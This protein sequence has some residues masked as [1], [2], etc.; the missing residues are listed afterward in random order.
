[1][2]RADCIKSIIIGVAVIAAALIPYFL[3]ECSFRKLSPR[4]ICIYGILA[5]IAFAFYKKQKEYPATIC[6]IVVGIVSVVFSQ[7]VVLGLTYELTNSFESCFNSVSFF[8]IWII[9][10]PVYSI[11]FYYGLLGGVLLLNKTTITHPSVHVDKKKLLLIILLS[12]IVYF[13][14]FYP[15]VF[16]FDAAV[17]LRTLLDP[18]CATCNHHPYFIQLIHGCFFGLG[19]LLG[20][21]SVG[22]ALLSL[23]LIATSVGILYYTVILLEKANIN[24]KWIISIILIYSLLPI[25]PYLSVYPTKDGIFAYSFLLYLLTLY[26]LFITRGQCLNQARFLC[27][28]FIAGLLICLSRHQGSI[29]FVIEAIV[30]LIAYKKYWQRLLSCSISVLLLHLGFTKII[31]PLND[32]EPA[33]KQETYGILFQQTAYCLKQYPDDVTA[34]EREAINTILNCDTIV[35]KYEASKTDAVKNTYKYNPW[36]RVAPNSPSMFRH[37]DRTN[38]AEELAAY[39]SAWLS[40]FLRHPLTHIEASAAVFWGFFYNNGQPLILAEPTWAENPSATT[41]EY[42]FWHINKVAEWIKKKNETI[43]QTPIINWI[44]AIPYY[45]WLAIFLLSILFLRNDW[46]GIIHFLP[47]ILSVGVLLICPVAFGRYIFPIVI[48]LPILLSY[49][50]SSNQ[51]Q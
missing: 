36:Y 13:I 15:C 17:G 2:K 25:F 43:T 4:S 6:K 11:S 33:G 7:F 8:I 39:K 45:N 26:E 40:M 30:L 42:R 41:P 23:I 20:H 35:Q 28:H 14:A 12:R 24:K 51:R 50:L 37:I 21:I 34:S 1:M 46:Q 22:F 49:L 38:E 5:A 9:Q 29:I 44:G 10:T 48:A 47:V 3:G 32:V 27:L 31:T 16:G 19:Q 18:Q